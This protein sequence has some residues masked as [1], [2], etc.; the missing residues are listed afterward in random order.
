MTL[1]KNYHIYI[2]LCNDGSYYIGHTSNLGR[3]FS[4][5]TQGMDSRCYTFLRRPL[6]MVFSSECTHRFVAF[7][8]ERKIKNWSNAKKWWTFVFDEN[9]YKY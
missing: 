6:K 4:E 8:L 5:H 7:L 1:E 2:L 3:R 9:P